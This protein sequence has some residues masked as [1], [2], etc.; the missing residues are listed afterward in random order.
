MEDTTVGLVKWWARQTTTNK[1]WVLVG[2]V[3]AGLLWWN[4]KQAGTI[5]TLQNEFRIVQVDCEQ[6][7]F[8]KVQEQRNK[9]DS[10]YAH[11]QEQHIADL[12]ACDESK[13]V[14][15]LDR[16]YANKDNTENIKSVLK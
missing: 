12:K 2:G 11:L 3:I 9:D 16:K 13:K 5:A 1:L 10:I 15:F 8:R 6:A 14:W 7:A 4:I